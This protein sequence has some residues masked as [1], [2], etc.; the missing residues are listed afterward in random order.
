[1]NLINKNKR[2]QAEK[3]TPRERRAGMDRRVLTYDYYIPERRTS[4]ERRS[5][6]PYAD[7]DDVH[8]EWRGRR[9][10]A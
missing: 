3:E 9:R 5:D 6:E 8:G 10:Y 7:R 4:V 1:M 2:Q